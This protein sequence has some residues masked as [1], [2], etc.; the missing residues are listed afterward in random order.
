MQL[1]LNII[2]T[3]QFA[4]GLVC[5]VIDIIYLVEALNR[6]SHIEMDFSPVLIFYVCADVYCMSING[7][8]IITIEYNW[9]RASR[10]LGYIIYWIEIG[11]WIPYITMKFLITIFYYD[12]IFY[13]MTIIFGCINLFLSI[14]CVILIPRLNRKLASEIINVPLR[15]NNAVNNAGIETVETNNAGAEI[16]N[17]GAEWNA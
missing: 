7:H 1:I 5:L 10:K 14:I 6:I 4:C 12:Y 2:R 9:N 3:L 11:F 15:R 8:Y 16:N 13:F 17:A